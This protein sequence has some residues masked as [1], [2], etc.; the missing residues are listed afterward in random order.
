MGF[1][2]SKSIFLF[3]EKNLLKLKV[4]IEINIIN[5]IYIHM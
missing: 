3:I 4:I 2:F 1:L 5:S